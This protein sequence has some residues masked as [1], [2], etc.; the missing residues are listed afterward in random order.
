MMARW[1]APL[2]LLVVAASVSGCGFKAW[3][4]PQKPEDKFYWMQAEAERSMDCMVVK[5]QLSGAYQNLDHVRLYLQRLGDGE[6]EGCP[7]CP[8][9][10]DQVLVFRGEDQELTLHG[11]F[12]TVGICGLEIGRA[13]KWRL[14]GRNVYNS[15]APVRT[16]VDIVNP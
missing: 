1:I 6:G 14:E 8:F 2:L 11:P 12:V 4:E 13:Y 10:A 9:R 7:G 5:A 3:P 16:E 15:M